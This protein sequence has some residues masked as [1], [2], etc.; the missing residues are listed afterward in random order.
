MTVSTKLSDITGISLKKIQFPNAEL[1]EES[2]LSQELW[3]NGPVLIQVV[4]RPVS[5]FK[6][7]F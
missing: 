4:R 3:A 5:L 2:V 1:K 7:I 6:P